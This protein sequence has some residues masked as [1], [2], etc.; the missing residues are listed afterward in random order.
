MLSV[1]LTNVLE[2]L[3]NQNMQLEIEYKGKIYLSKKDEATSAKDFCEQ[4][5]EMFD[6]V[7]KFT[8]VLE[9]GSILLLGELACQTAAFRF[10]G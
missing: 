7:S 4:M 6:D 1:L 10:L 9:D 5:Y 3:L 8:V 2:S